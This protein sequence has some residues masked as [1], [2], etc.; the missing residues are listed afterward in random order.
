MDGP[1]PMCGNN[2]FTHHNNRQRRRGQ[3]NI[4]FT[5]GIAVD[6]PAGIISATRLKSTTQQYKRIGS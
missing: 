6:K 2:N 3:E 1:T 4:E 5:S